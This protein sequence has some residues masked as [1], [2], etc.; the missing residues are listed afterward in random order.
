MTFDY[1]I[2]TCKKEKD[3]REEK[4]LAYL[5]TI[6]NHLM[7]FISNEVNNNPSLTMKDINEIIY[8]KVQN[9]LS[10]MN[11]LNIRN[12]TIEYYL[13]TSSYSN[14]LNFRNTY[15]KICEDEIAGKINIKNIDRD[16]LRYTNNMKQN[17]ETLIIAGI[18]RMR[19]SK[20]AYSEAEG[21]QDIIG[22]LITKSSKERAA[23]IKKVVQGLDITEEEKRN[24]IKELEYTYKL[25]TKP[26]IE[27]VKES[28]NERIPKTSKLVK[29]E[30]IKAIKT[31][32]NLLDEFGLLEFYTDSN[33]K[34]Y[35]KI[36]INGIN[37]TYDEVKDMLKEDNL[38]K[39]NVEDLIVMSAFWTNR[40]NK[41]IKQLN[42][43][44]YV[45]NH[46]E[47]IKEK[48][49]EN[50]L[51]EYKATD[52]DMKNVDFKMN[53]IH[54][55]YFELFEQ[56]QEKSKGN[57]TIDIK[58]YLNGI[59][60]KHQNNYKEYFDIL[61]PNSENSLKDDLNIANIFENVRY[62]SYQI[63]DVYMQALLISLFSGN[64]NI[65]NYGYIP[66]EDQKKKEILIAAD[67]KG[68]NMPFSL[69]INKDTVLNFIEE[70]QGDMMF[71]LYKNMSDF[72]LNKDSMLKPQIFMPLTKEADKVI[73]QA[74][75]TTTPRDRY[76]KAVMHLNYLRK[77]GKMPEHM[78]Q[79]CVDKKGR[80]MKYVREYTDLSKYGVNI[81]KER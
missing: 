57:Q 50:G 36:Y 77:D 52:Q 25:F 22:E 30:C 4:N 28:F 39:L 63:K 1:L 27:L 70:Y 3:S 44:V 78:M 61:F 5:N 59:A 17:M 24:V 31:S 49:L 74:A 6:L 46:R 58:R 15:K 43:A 73:K 26:E 19:E 55:L 13:G 67:I 42:N 10:Q 66:E 40:V 23:F 29:D 64:K 2:R 75:D 68:F 38:K 48:Q 7:T 14:D 32:T 9:Y 45:V 12:R 47:L 8:G 76:G 81:D 34:A 60:R 62:N 53:V 56:L 11:E 65:E 71:P 16:E 18:S 33:N 35:K 54:K 37:Y 80:K 41:V 79:M 69:H 20:E 72:Y 51:F 21:M